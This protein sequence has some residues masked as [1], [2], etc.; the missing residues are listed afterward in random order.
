[1]AW[2]IELSVQVELGN[3][4]PQQSKRILKFLH[5]RLARLEHPRSIG[6]ALQGSK[7]GEFWKYRVGDYRLQDRRQSASH[8]RSCRPPQRN[9]PLNKKRGSQLRPLLLTEPPQSAIYGRSA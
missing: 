5:E 7:L 4:D 3:L 1:M 9:L 8:S 6:Q 2:K